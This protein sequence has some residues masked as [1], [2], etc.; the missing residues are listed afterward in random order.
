MEHLEAEDLSKPILHEGASRSRSRSPHQKLPHDPEE[1]EI[2]SPATASAQDRGPRNC[3]MPAV[4]KKLA[5]PEMVKPGDLMKLLLEDPP[6]P[7]AN[8]PEPEE[9]PG[10]DRFRSRSPSEPPQPKKMPKKGRLALQK[11]KEA[12][13]KEGVVLQLTPKAHAPKPPR[14]LRSDLDTASRSQSSGSRDPPRCQL[15]AD[16]DRLETWRE[17]QASVRDFLQRFTVETERQALA[18][19][20]LARHSARVGPTAASKLEA[21]VMGAAAEAPADEAKIW[22]FLL[23][24]QGKA[25]FNQAKAKAKA[26]YSRGR[27]PTIDN[28]VRWELRCGC[29]S[30]NLGVEARDVPFSPAQPTPPAQPEDDPREKGELIL[31]PICII[32]FAHND[33]S[34]HFVHGDGDCSILQLA[35]ELIA[36][37]TAMEDV[38]PFT[39]C[40]HANQ[41]YCRSGNRR[42]AA[43]CLAAMFAPDRFHCV[44]VRWVKTDA[45][46]LRGRGGPR[47]RPKLSTHLNGEDCEGQWLVVRETGEAVAG[48]PGVLNAPPYGADL[49]SLLP[50]PT[51]R[52]EWEK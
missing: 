17:Y 51:P 33:Q 23:T 41:W 3:L 49:L 46:F 43:F 44:W 14:E 10:T 36:G 42:L 11:A 4:A 45:I 19:E 47:A 34:E 32:G 21:A 25:G 8:E 18:M 13:M 20:V 50:H 26:Q 28:E 2:A 9:A 37:V 40:R 15:Q 12:E 38:P 22:N 48:F 1:D 24:A 5:R 31:L 27:N 16:G 7:P 30:E 29:F 6:D 39:V 35:V 52:D